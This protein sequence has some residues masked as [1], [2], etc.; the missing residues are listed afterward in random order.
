MRRRPLFGVITLYGLRLSM[1]LG[2][3]RMHSPSAGDPIV[4]TPLGSQEAH[5]L[6]VLQPVIVIKC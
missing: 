5:Q 3:L 4:F 6:G 2:E 1:S